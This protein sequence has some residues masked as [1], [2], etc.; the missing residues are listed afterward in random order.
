MS[1]DD[2]KDDAPPPEADP[3]TG[4]FDMTDYS[5]MSGAVVMHDQIVRQVS[6]LLAE[7]DLSEDEKQKILA[8]IVCPCCGGAGPSMVFDLNPT[9]GDGPVY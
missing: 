4:M 5:G 6:D 3:T 1:D 9:K 7:S 8:S 2:R